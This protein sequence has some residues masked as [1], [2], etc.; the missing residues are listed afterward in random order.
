MSHRKSGLRPIVLAS[1]FAFCA[2]PA[3]A[4]RPMA[5]DDAGTL[6]RDGAKL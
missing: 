3:F 2:A 5:V 6:E 1:P 4:E